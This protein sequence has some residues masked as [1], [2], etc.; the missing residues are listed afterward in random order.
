MCDV[1]VRCDGEVDGSVQADFARLVRA[2]GTLNADNY[3]QDMILLWKRFLFV[4]DDLKVILLNHHTITWILSS[5]T[6]LSLCHYCYHYHSR[7]WQ[8]E[9][10]VTSLFGC[11]AYAQSLNASDKLLVVKLFG[12]ALI[13]CL[14]TVK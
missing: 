14:A 1:L 6:I 4:A 8:V 10:V 7:A 5:I 13:E 12:E 11:G 2:D 9:A 3:K